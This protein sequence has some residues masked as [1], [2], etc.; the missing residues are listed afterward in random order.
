VLIEADPER[1]GR[2]IADATSNTRLSG[3]ARPLAR[4]IVTAMDPSSAYQADRAAA[5]SGV[6]RST[7]HYWSRTGVLI[8]SV[9]SER[10]KLWSYSDLMALRTI[11][12]LRQAKP[13]TGQFVTHPDAIFHERSDAPIP[14]STMPAVRR[15]LE[16]LKELDLK[17]WSEE[18]GA[19]VRVTRSGEVFVDAADGIES[20]YRE[21]V[22]PDTLDLIAPFDTETTRGPHLH[23][24]RPHLRI[25]PGKLAGS[26]HIERTRI[27][28]LTIAALRQRG[29]APDKI[30]RLYP[31]LERDAIIE[32]IDLEQQ[33]SRNLLGTVA[34]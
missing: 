23:I 3:V 5:L 4:D 7:V 22:L 1:E 26:P 11:Y 24:P 33:L 10:V 12:W 6:P 21:R 14:A 34:A 19:A 31:D 17:L 25:V 9:S 15:S 30:N 16:L 29:F 2:G 13:N 28:T 8:P 27:E 32:A 20:G 18:R